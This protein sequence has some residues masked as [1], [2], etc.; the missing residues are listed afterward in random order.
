ME[1]NDL[2]RSFPFLTF[3]FHRN[4][5]FFSF[6]IFSILSFRGEW[7]L[8]KKKSKKNIYIYIYVVVTLKLVVHSLSLPR[9]LETFFVPHIFDQQRRQK[10]N[11]HPTGC[12]CPL[13]G[14]SDV[15]TWKDK[16]IEERKETVWYAVT[17]YNVALTN[18][19]KPHLAEQS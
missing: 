5:F 2:F 14:L 9:N 15:C 12:C 3:F 19:W 11:R 13:T 17:K 4:K 10:Y 16:I 7:K 8:M 6:H 1:K 18:K